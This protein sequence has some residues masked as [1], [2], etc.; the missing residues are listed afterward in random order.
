MG[1]N[2]RCTS[3]QRKLFFLLWMLAAPPRPPLNLPEI[4]GRGRCS[5][6]LGS[7]SPALPSHGSS[8][9]SRAI[10]VTRKRAEV[11]E[12]CLPS[13]TE[14]LAKKTNDKVGRSTP[15]RTNEQRAV[16]YAAHAIRSASW[17][18][19]DGLRARTAA[20]HSAPRCTGAS[21][22]R[23]F[24]VLPLSLFL[25]HRSRSP[26]GCRGAGARGAP[27]AFVPQADDADDDVHGIVTTVSG[28]RPTDSRASGVR[29]RRPSA[30]RTDGRGAV[31]ARRCLNAACSPHAIAEQSS[32]RCAASWITTACSNSPENLRLS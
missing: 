5:H 8:P 23:S 11:R 24:L 1:Q 18:H 26:P 21:G 10:D 25:V 32:C 27:R 4:G 6:P 15:P 7:S 22:R 2:T 9:G 3:K 29:P 19:S 13:S 14:R 30:L 17:R 31:S 16:E 20:L 28:H 12:F